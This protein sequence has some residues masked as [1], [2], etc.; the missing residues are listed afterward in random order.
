[1]ADGNI[2]FVVPEPAEWGMLFG[3]LA[4]LLALAFRRKSR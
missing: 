3:A 2:T 1:M 4:M